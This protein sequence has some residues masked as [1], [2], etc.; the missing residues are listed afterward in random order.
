MLLQNWSHHYRSFMVVIMN[1]WI[2]TV[3]T[4]APWKVICS[5]CHDIPFLFPLP[6]T[7]LFMSNLA[8]VSRKAEDTYPTS[9][10][11]PFSEVLVEYDLLIYFCYFVCIILVISYSLLCL[12]FFHVWSLTL[13]YILLISAGNLV[14]LIKIAKNV[15]FCLSRAITL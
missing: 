6:C 10:P 11:G 13:F 14:P 12:S 9:T 3:Y 7:W 4:S 1:L 2:V 5:T 15:S 8:G